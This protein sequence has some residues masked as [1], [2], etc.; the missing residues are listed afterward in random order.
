MSTAVTV[1]TYSHTVTHVTAKMLYSLQRIIQQIGL[2]AGKIT[3]DWDNLERGIST[4]L[5]SQ[6]LQRVI[7]EVWNPKSDALIT[8][9]DI[10][11]NYGY[12]GDGSLWADID[13]IKYAIQKAGTVAILCEYR[14]IVTRSAG[15][16]E[17][18]GWTSATLRSTD[19]LKQYSVGSTI[20]GNGI[21]AETSYWR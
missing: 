4:W 1:N 10:E 19:H 14:I 20:G 3:S 13:G 9:W 21:A 15:Y 6:H 2:D 18:L 17:V 8:R 12:T 5:K 7:L 16:P 11:V